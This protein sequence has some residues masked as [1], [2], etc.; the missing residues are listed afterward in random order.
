MLSRQALRLPRATASTVRIQKSVNPRRDL[1]T[2]AATS[3]S[4]NDIFANGTNTYYVEEMYRR[5]RAPF[6]ALTTCQLMEFKILRPFSCDRSNL[7][8]VHIG[9]A[10]CPTEYFYGYSAEKSVRFW[11]QRVST[12][13]NTNLRW[14]G[15]PFQSAGMTTE[16]G[17][18]RA[19]WVSNLIDIYIHDNRFNP[20][21]IAGLQVE[22]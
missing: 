12:N 13:P 15:K 3:P 22:G 2:P 1:A 7:L 11:C 9:T 8:R 4:A 5:W 17:I 21:T 19:F 6:L 16:R 14:R 20:S 18:F 10:S